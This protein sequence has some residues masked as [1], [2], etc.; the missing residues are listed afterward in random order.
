MQVVISTV[1]SVGLD[2]ELV[3]PRDVIFL[4]GRYSKADD[5]VDWVAAHEA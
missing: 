4:M 1:I 3:A 2:D 5:A